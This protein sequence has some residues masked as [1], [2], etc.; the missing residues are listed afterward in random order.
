MVTQLTSGGNPYRDPV[1]FPGQ[2]A[3]DLPAEDVPA[4]VDFSP[5]GSGG[6]LIPEALAANGQPFRT[7]RAF[8]VS[9]VVAALYPTRATV[10]AEM[11]IGDL[12]HALPDGSAILADSDED[13][14]AHGVVVR[15][16]SATSVYWSPKALIFLA[17]DPAPEADDARLWLGPAGT[18]LTAAPVF[19]MIERI[20]EVIRH[21][22]TEDLYLCRFSLEPA[23]ASSR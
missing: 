18:I 1:A 6:V 15:I 8:P 9:G 21:D 17:L 7:P 12:V 2:G 22:T 4:L 5:F 14:E 23:A 20:G 13:V 11:S 3:P 10:A 16:E 19:G